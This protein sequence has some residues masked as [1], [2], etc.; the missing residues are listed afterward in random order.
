MHQ[1]NQRVLW[2][3]Q[4]H[5]GRKNGPRSTKK[6]R[7]RFSFCIFFA[8]LRHFKSIGVHFR[9]L[10]RYILLQVFLA[11]LFRIIEIFHT[12]VL[13]FQN[14]LNTCLLIVQFMHFRFDTLHSFA[15]TPYQDMCCVLMFHIILG[16]SNQLGEHA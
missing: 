1:K 11:S 12:K 5:L 4:C 10:L 9:F 3:L 8:F 16:W 15:V 7:S 13:K 2:S 6:W 14:G